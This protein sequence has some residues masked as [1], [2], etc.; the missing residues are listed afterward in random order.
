[1]EAQDLEVD[2]QPVATVYGAKMGRLL[3]EGLAARVTSLADLVRARHAERISDS[4][5]RVEALADKARAWLEGSADEVRRELAD[6]VAQADRAGAVPSLFSIMGTE[7]LERPFNNVLAWLCDPRA[8]HGVGVPVLRALAEMLGEARLLDD[9]AHDPDN[10]SLVAEGWPLDFAGEGQPDIVVAAPSVVVLIENKVWSPES[11]DDQ[12]AKYLRSLKSLA[13][14]HGRGCAAYLLSR[15]RRSAP[16]EGDD[17]WDGARTHAQLV[18][19][20]SRVAD[21]PA[22]SAWGRVLCLLCASELSPVERHHGSLD[23]A[24]S[25]LRAEQGRSSVQHLA[26]MRHL[27]A[28]ISIPPLPYREHPR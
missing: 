15:D 9:L 17:A 19:A 4:A 2:G 7:R 3:P 10:V 27:A 18:A 13:A 22:I 24:R 8:A 21:D 6:R 16:G 1:M 23:R 25:L 14:L 26:E 28:A 5:D 12:Y 20:V 11:G